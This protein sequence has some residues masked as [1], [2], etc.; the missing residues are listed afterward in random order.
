MVESEMP[1]QWVPVPGETS[2][3]PPDA[4]PQILPLPSLTAPPWAPPYLFCPCSPKILTD[5]SLIPLVLPR[6]LL[7]LTATVM[8]VP[9]C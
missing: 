9:I 3:W 4:Q 7:L 6:L 5:R 1:G 8:A 2:R